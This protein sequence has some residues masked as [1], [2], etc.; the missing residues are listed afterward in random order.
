MLDFFIANFILSFE[1][2]LQKYSLFFQKLTS[3]FYKEAINFNL[4]I[5]Y[6]LI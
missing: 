5:K 3:I 6:N 1:Y 2:I 4:R